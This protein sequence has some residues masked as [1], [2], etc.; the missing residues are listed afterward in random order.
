MIYEVS[1]DILLTKTQ[2]IA[3]GISPNDPFDA[4][5][6]LA[7]RDRWPMMHKDYRHYAHQKHPEPGT[8]WEWGGFGIRIFNLITQDGSFDHG[9]RPGRASLSNVDHCLKALRKKLIEDKITSVALPRLATGV[10]G[11]AWDDVRPLIRQHLGDMLIPVIVYGTYHAGQ[12]ADEPG[13]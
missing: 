5:L 2:A 4:G 1:G 12:Q 7:L 6:A 10:G 8:L 3:H 11:L 13:L 9:A